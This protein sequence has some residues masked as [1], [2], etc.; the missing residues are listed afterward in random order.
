M[1]R[2][3]MSRTFS[4][5]KGSFDLE[6]T[7][8]MRLYTKH[9]EPTMYRGFGDARMLRHG[10]DASIRSLG[11]LAVQGG[12]AHFGHPLG[13]MGAGTTGALFLLQTFKSLFQIVPSPFAHRHLADAQTTPSDN[14]G[15]PFSTS[16][17]HSC[18]LHHPMGLRSGTGHA[19][20]LVFPLAIK[21]DGCCWTAS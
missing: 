9:L 18:M 13:T 2:P 11:R 17:H 12:I 3:T 8:T 7:L 19:A 6:V 15:L 10:T 1:Y 21:P 14:M 20:Q 5:K 4:T 16:Q